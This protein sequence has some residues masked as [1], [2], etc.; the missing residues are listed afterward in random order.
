MIWHW[1]KDEISLIPS[2]HVSA[3]LEISTPYCRKLTHG[4]DLW[5]TARE[6]TITTEYLRKPFGVIISS[7]TAKMRIWDFLL[8]ISGGVSCSFPPFLWWLRDTNTELGKIRGIPWA[9]CL[10]MFKRRNKGTS[11]KVLQSHVALQH[12]LH[13]ETLWSGCCFCT[14][15]CKVSWPVGFYLLWDSTS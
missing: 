3:N 9:E 8:Q 7:H 4:R 6:D 14:F 5:N 15:H 11:G 2:I 10:W 13:P 12:L 1:E